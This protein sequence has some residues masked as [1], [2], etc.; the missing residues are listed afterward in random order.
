MQ[1][2]ARVQNLGSGPCLY[3]N[4]IAVIIGGASN[5]RGTIS[6]SEREYMN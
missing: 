2:K 4:I 6:D 5:F 1:D 3:R